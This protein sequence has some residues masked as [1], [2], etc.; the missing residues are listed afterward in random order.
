MFGVG[1][2]VGFDAVAFVSG[3]VCNRS[4]VFST[5][6]VSSLERVGSRFWCGAGRDGLVEVR[7]RVSA[8]RC[9]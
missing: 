6:C 8:F 1:A 5:L 3:A 9:V 4:E 7:H 2:V